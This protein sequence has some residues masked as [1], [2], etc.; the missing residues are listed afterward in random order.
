MAQLRDIKNR[1]DSVKKTKKITQAMKM[2]AAAKFK[3]ATE[4]T[5]KARPYLESLEDV[6]LD[7]NKRADVTQLPLLM[8]ENESDIEVAIVISGDRGLCGGFNANIIKFAEKHVHSQ[9][10]RP[11]LLLIGNKGFQN[12]KNKE[13]NIDLHTEIKNEIMT[14]TGIK[15]LISPVVKQ[16]QEGKIGRLVIL[17][18]EFASAISSNLIKKQLLPVSILSSEET[19][20]D[21]SDFF[22][23]PSQDSIIDYALEEFIYF[24]VFKALLES[25]AAEE[26]ARMAAMDAASDNASDMIKSLTLVYN[27]TRQAKITSEISEIVAGAEASA[28]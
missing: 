10:K 7:F 2:V 26:G 27:R 13:V 21:T 1:I 14:F 9:I 20:T 25:K 28:Q 24:S 15:Q 8:N 11:N 18:N 19:D 5:V 6:L 12:F 4:A 23:E 3:R 17:Y 22:Y 16:F